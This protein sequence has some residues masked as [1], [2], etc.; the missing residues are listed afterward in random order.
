MEGKG[1]AKWRKKVDSNLARRKGVDR[2]KDKIKGERG[3]R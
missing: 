1:E 2:I 3:W